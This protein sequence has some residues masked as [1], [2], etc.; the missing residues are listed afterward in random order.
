MKRTKLSI[1]VP[2][3]Y[4]EKNIP[5]TFKRLHALA[6]SI[7]NMDIEYVFVDDGSGDNSYQE[8][9]KLRK[10]FRSVKVVK[11]SRNFG[12]FN[13]ILA[14]LHYA[15]GD[16]IGIISA[17]LQ[18]PPELFIEMVD[19]WRQGKKTVMAVRKN[20]QDP[21]VSKLLSNTFYWLIR[22]FAI[23]AMP[24]GG[25]DFVLIDRLVK[26]TLIRMNEKN[27]SLMGLISWLGFESGIVYYTRT[28]REI[29]TSRW[30]LSKKFKYFVDT[31]TAFSYFPI[32]AIST[33]GFIIAVAGFIYA[34]F[35]LFN[36][37]VFGISVQGWTSMIIVVLVISG[38]Q[39]TSLG[40]IGEYLW[41]N[42][43]ETRKRPNFIVDTVLE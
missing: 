37:A 1:V 8:L 22:K 25:F 26:D 24:A 40:I 30:N 41:R 6:T 39:L 27:T 28:K 23:P 4:N 7:K 9:L 14:G 10:H 2:V 5:V 12:S 19:Q 38:V 32:R 29:G 43:D 35:V 16:C 17:D 33:L 34:A 3:Y 20:R 42:I 18:D 36:K 15:T 11:L 31:F 13:A 21:F